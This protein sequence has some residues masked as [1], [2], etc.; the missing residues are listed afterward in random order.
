MVEAVRA[1]VDEKLILCTGADRATYQVRA[2]PVE[3]WVKDTHFLAG[4]GIEW[5]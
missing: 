3:A 5:P 1:L 4:A 2:L